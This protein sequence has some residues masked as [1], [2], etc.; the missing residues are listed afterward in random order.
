M[1][2]GYQLRYIRFIDPAYEKRLTVPIIPF[3][4]IDEVGA[5]MYKGEH[6]S[7]AERHLG[8]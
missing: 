1:Q 6:V 5:G 3:S 8:K 2:P 4:A 7:M